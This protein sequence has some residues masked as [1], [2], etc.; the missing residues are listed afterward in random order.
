MR[1][2]ERTEALLSNL[3]TPK[4]FKG[5][6][7]LAPKRL[8]YGL[9]KDTLVK[10]VGAVEA[11]Q[12]LSDPQWFVTNRLS[13]CQ[14]DVGA[15]TQAVAGYPYGSTPSIPSLLQHVEPITNMEMAGM[16]E[17]YGHYGLFDSAWC[18]MILIESGLLYARHHFESGQGCGSNM[19]AVRYL[20]KRH[21][22]ACAASSRIIITISRLLLSGAITTENFVQFELPLS[23]EQKALSGLMS[24]WKDVWTEQF[25]GKD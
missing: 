6:I 13:A 14:F 21:E 12:K 17:F 25:R 3:V 16:R 10:A 8:Q 4:A 11:W 5:S 1:K 2:L 7:T 18:M 22:E 24:E 9:H 19:I 15:S 23:R 20:L